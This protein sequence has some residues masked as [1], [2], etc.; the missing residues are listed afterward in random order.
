M[1]LISVLVALA[2]FAAGCGGSAAADDPSS[3]A[4]STADTA[5]DGAGLAEQVAPVVVVGEALPAF[6]QDQQFTTDVADDNAIGMVAPTITGTSFDGTETTVGPDGTPRVVMFVAHWCPHCQREIPVVMDL[7]GSGSL[8][9]NLEIVA[10]S[11]AV[12]PDEDLYPPQEWLEAEGWSNAIIRDGADFEALRAYGAGGFPYT[13]Y[14][15][16]DNEVVARSAGELPAET[17]EQLWLAAAD[18]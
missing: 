9:A 10:V 12:R 16:G 18:S 14:L 17:I 5:A 13:V 7:I 6:P 2:L 1:R 11:T 3:D 15:N 8:P 4:P